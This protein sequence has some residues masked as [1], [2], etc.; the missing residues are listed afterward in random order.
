MI[1]AVQIVKIVETLLE[2][3]ADAKWTNNKLSSL[4][5][6]LAYSPMSDT[7]KEAVMLKLIEAGVDVNS[8]AGSIA[9]TCG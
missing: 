9:L 8:Q 2:N 7:D 4:L 1:L 5:H 3:G 6:F